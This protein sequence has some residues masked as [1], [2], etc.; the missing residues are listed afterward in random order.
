[1]KTQTILSLYEKWGNDNYDE[2]ITQLQHGLQCA[3]FAEQDGASPSLVV[4][5]LLHDIG[6]LL[7]LERCHGNVDIELNDKHDITGS[8]Y[9]ANFF[10]PEV[11]EP[12]R[13][14]V[15]AKRYLCSVDATYRSTLSEASEKSLLFQGGPMNEDEI[16][17]FEKLPYFSD[18]VMLRRWDERG[19]IQNM[20]T[21]GFT[22]FATAMASLELEQ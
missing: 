19:K 11:T 20:N 2:K 18:A 9:L 15:H 6:H 3:F 1:M 14:H 10:G 4:A 16:R 12:I 7:E 21:P 5:A 22:Y 8:E 13:L 17:K